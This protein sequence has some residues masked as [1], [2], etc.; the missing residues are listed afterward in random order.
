MALANAPSKAV[1]DQCQVV[2]TRS[3]SYRRVLTWFASRWRNHQPKRAEKPHS[4]F[5]VVRRWTALLRGRRLRL[6]WRIASGSR[7]PPRGARLMSARERERGGLPS[8]SLSLLD[9]KVGQGLIVFQMGTSNIKHP[10]PNIQQRTLHAS[11]SW[12]CARP[13]SVFNFQHLSFSNEFRFP[14]SVFNF[15]M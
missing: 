14:L 8:P 1:A 4:K 2:K 6:P 12:L 9:R 5:T 11:W 10:P 15:T 3:Q 13:L 7:Q